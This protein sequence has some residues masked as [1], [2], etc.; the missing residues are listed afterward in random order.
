[1]PIIRKNIHNAT[2]TPA[3][4]DTQASIGGWGW[5]SPYDMLNMLRDLQNLYDRDAK[6]ISPRETTVTRIMPTPKT[7]GPGAFSH[8]NNLTDKVFKVETVRSYVISDMSMMKFFSEAAYSVPLRHS[9]CSIRSF[10]NYLKDY[11][12]EKKIFTP[13][14]FSNSLGRDDRE[15]GFSVYKPN[16]KITL[17]EGS[18]KLPTIIRSYFHK[19]AKAMESYVGSA[20]DPRTN[21]NE[22]NYQSAKLAYNFYTLA[23]KRMQNEKSTLLDKYLSDNVTLQP[24][25]SVKMLINRKWMK[26]RGMFG[27]HGSCFYPGR[28]HSPSCEIM[29]EIGYIVR[30]YETHV[31]DDAILKNPDNP[32]GVADPLDTLYEE[33][34]DEHATDNTDGCLGRCI[35]L[36]VWLTNK[37]R[38]ARRQQF[39]ENFRDH[40]ADIGLVNSYSHPSKMHGIDRNFVADALTA[41]IPGAVKT[42]K[43]DLYNYGSTYINGGACVPVTLQNFKLELGIP[44]ACLTMNAFDAINEAYGTDYDD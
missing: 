24:S 20:N 39:P 34:Y 10:D 9:S 37:E 35:I 8:L 29:P 6:P 41:L 4:L 21:T 15:E 23:N 3:S 36:P 7:L 43:T 28:E 1:M 38:D 18:P 42:P 5:G 30:L 26:Y 32:L 40:N 33:D 2:V 13:V 19:I 17:P 31:P 27:D 11:L 22:T 25:T 14:Q 12:A 44:L 16:Y